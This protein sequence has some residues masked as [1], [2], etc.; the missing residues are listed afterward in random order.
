MGPICTMIAEIKVLAIRK[1]WDVDMIDGG[2]KLFQEHFLLGRNRL[3]GEK[4]ANEV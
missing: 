1:G 4:E 2:S 3:C